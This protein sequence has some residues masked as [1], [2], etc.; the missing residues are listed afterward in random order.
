MLLFI[1]YNRRFS[2]GEHLRMHKIGRVYRS[3]KTILCFHIYHP[4][5]IDPR[6]DAHAGLI[7]EL[8]LVSWSEFHR[9]PLF[10]KIT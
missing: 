5:C 4:F 9:F 6:D 8:H 2:R 7:L 1:M 3:L 10:C